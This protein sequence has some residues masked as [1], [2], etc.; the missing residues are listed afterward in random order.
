MNNDASNGSS[1]NGSNEHSRGRR[2]V[3]LI[4]YIRRLV[5][6]AHTAPTILHGLF[7]SQYPAGILPLLEIERRNYL[8][9]ARSA[10]WAETKRKYDEPGGQHCTFLSPLESLDGDEMEAAEGAWERWMQMETWA[11]Q[12]RRQTDMSFMDGEMGGVRVKREEDA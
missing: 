7:G 6:T 1:M 12:G 11:G 10:G 3:S 8:F 9:T 5:V 4:P 2:V